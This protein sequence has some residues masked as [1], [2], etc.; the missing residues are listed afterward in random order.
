MLKSR[1]AILSCLSVV[2]IACLAVLLIKPKKDSRY[3]NVCS[4]GGVAKIKAV[5]IIS[6]SSSEDDK[7]GG[8]ALCNSDKYDLWE[9]MFKMYGGRNYIEFIVFFPDEMTANR[10]NMPYDTPIFS[11]L[12]FRGKKDVIIIC[13][14]RKKIIKKAGRIDMAFIRKVHEVLSGTHLDQDI[15]RQNMPVR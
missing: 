2:L 1:K 7:F 10:I 5:Y 13:Q 4:Y 9:A 6:R 11:K 12:K 8:C 14:H 15:N 3:I